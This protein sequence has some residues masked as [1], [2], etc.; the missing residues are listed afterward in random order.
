MALKNSNQPLSNKN[1]NQITVVIALNT[2]F[3]IVAV[4]KVISSIRYLH[5]CMVNLSCKVMN[6]HSISNK[7]SEGVILR[8]VNHQ[9]L[10]L[11]L[12][13]W[14]NTIFQRKTKKET[15]ITGIYLRI[16]ALGKNS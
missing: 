11:K 12:L 9:Q 7:D 4:S 16:K 1:Q 8:R 6:E 13:I 2:A 14:E 5:I 10:S 3:E 15:H